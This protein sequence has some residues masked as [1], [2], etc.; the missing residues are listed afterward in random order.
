MRSARKFL[1]LTLALFKIWRASGRV[2]SSFPSFRFQGLAGLTAVLRRGLSPR[3][4]RPRPA[5]FRYGQVARG[6]SS[7]PVESPM[8]RQYGRCLFLDHD[9]WKER[10][11]PDGSPTF[12]LPRFSSLRE[13]PPPSQNAGARGLLLSP[14][15]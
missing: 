7:C 13:V 15:R 4:A 9:E 14:R 1:N 8:A 6:T 2:I 5:R 3:F 10:D 11:L 12:T